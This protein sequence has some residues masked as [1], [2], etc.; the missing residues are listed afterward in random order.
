MDGIVL[1]IR[2]NIQLEGNVAQLQR[3][4]KNEAEATL[5][6]RKICEDL[7]KSLEIC[8]KV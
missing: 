4:L 8:R 2:K 3:D 7:S 1:L 6:E 5:K